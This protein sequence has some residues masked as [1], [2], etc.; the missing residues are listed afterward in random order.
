M[1]PQHRFSKNQTM[2]L[3]RVGSVSIVVNGVPTIGQSPY[4]S[5]V[6]LITVEQGAATTGVVSFVG[7][8][9]RHGAEYDP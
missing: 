3:T 6:Q 2:F 9:R 1:I 7:C 8:G 5:I 4:G